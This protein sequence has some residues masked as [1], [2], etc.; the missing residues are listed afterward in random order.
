VPVRLG[1]HSWLRRVRHAT[2]AC[3]DCDKDDLTWAARNRVYI[4]EVV[5]R[6]TNNRPVAQFLSIT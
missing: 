5:S 2:D 3:L 6:T 1:L 4:L